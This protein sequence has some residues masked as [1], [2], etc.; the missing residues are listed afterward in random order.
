MDDRKPIPRA[1]RKDFYCAGCERRLPL[2]Q[3]MPGRKCH[4][5]ATHNPVRTPLPARASGKRKFKRPIRE[6]KRPLK[7]I[8]RRG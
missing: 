2:E 4:S 5:C 8:E 3:M 7:I 1:K 6:Q